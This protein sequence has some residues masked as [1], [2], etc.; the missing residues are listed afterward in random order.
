MDIVKITVLKRALHADLARA[1][2]GVDTVPCE[3]LADGQVFYA[4]LNMPDGFCPWAWQDLT[5]MV[6]ALQSG[7][8][9]A[10]GAFQG[11]MRDD[12][13][14]VACCT[15]GFRPVSFKLERV[16]TRSL[17]DVSGLARPAPVGVYESERWGE[18]SYAVPGLAPGT[19]Y[20]ARLHFCE[21]YHGAPGKRRF[22]VE[23]GGRR[24][25]E[26]LD[27][28]AEAGGPYRP[29][30]REVEVAADASGALVL[31]FVKGTADQPKVSAIEIV[32]AAGGAPLHAINTGGSDCAP[33]VADR[34]FTGG[35]TMGG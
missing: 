1:I 17:I 12:H 33:F 3:M 29:I 18:F 34:F 14:A 13:T 28:V 7:G 10:R 6:V 5:R 11:W 20:R 21:V 25:V 16:D 22:H 27:I 30:V 35:R 31:A 19:R 4:G 26:D 15:D 23:S 32:S 9:F 8:S 24:L 2:R